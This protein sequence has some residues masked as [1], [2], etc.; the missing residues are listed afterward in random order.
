MVEVAGGPGSGRS[1][2]IAHVAAVLPA[3]PRLEYRDRA[4]DLEPGYA[5]PPRDRLCVFAGVPPYATEEPWPRLELA[6][7]GRD[8]FLEYLVARR[9]K[10]AGDILARLPG[11]RDPF[12]GIPEIWALVLD[13]LASAPGALGPRAALRLALMEKLG[14]GRPW[15]DVREICLSRL[16]DPVRLA[17]EVRTAL[18][19]RG[20]ADRLRRLL[21]HAPVWALLAADE[22]HE[23][24]EE[25]RIPD[26]LPVSIAGELAGRIGPT[27]VAAHRLGELV[28]GP[29][30]R[31]QRVAAEVIHAG[32]PEA[33][34]RLLTRRAESGSEM[35]N[36]SGAR[37]PGARWEGARLGG[38]DLNRADL[39]G[40][41][42]SGANIEG[43]IF[44]ATVLA[45]AT[46]ERASLEGCDLLQADLAG[47]E[48]SR[49]RLRGCRLDGL[50]LES[51]CFEGAS[52]PS[53]SF[54]DADLTG[55]RAP[56]ADFQEASFVRAG[57]ADVEWRG[58][59]LRGADFREATFHAGSTR[60]GLVGSPIASEGTRTGFYTD[61]RGDLW[62]RDPGEVRRADLREADLRAAKVLDTDLYLVDLRGARLDPEQ[63]DH[64]RRCGA[65]L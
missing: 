25:G 7:W 46:F 31:R 40:A 44:W 10:R 18:I 60:G 27:S 50:R 23:Q 47:T 28:E 45:G 38:L 34:G 35:G 48:F 51:R 37:L 65:I 42:L 41:I 6:P 55:F 16:E 36:L 33:L 8:E 52:F 13:R 9:V 53:C 64:A 4:G 24:L 5:P 58:A 32:D 15:R 1:T 59:D 62:C 49:A 2:A 56:G 39:S 30:D 20:A 26:H 12:G 21:R 19:R 22:A 43:V 57:L 63:V 3:T 29:E 11:S 14:A 61:D 17:D 54:A